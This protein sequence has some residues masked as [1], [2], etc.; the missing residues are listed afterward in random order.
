M[1][2][3]HT[4]AD[5]K[6]DIDSR[7]KNQWHKY[8]RRYRFMEN[9]YTYITLQIYIALHINTYIYIYIYVYIYIKFYI[10]IYTY[11]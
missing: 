2:Q 8:T 5:D 11:T 3:T 7:R 9:I 4:T 1:A 10:Y 6:V